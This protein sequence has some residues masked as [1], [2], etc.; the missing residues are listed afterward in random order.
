MADRKMAKTQVRYGRGAMTRHCSICAHF[1]PPKSCALVA[2]TIDPAAWC[3]LFE[4]AKVKADK[5]A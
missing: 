1:Q 2:G 5:H 4:R 3:R